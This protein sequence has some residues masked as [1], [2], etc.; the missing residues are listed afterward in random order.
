M[1]S[2]QG[3][4]RG[5]AIIYHVSG[6]SRSMSTKKTRSIFAFVSSEVSIP[7][8]YFLRPPSLVCELLTYRPRC[9][10]FFG[11]FLFEP[12][13][14]CQKGS[15]VLWLKVLRVCDAQACPGPR[16]HCAP[17]GAPLHAAPPHRPR[18]VKC[19]AMEVMDKK[20]SNAPCRV[21]L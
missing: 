15:L 5:V 18:P 16:R 13:P 10:F 1:F 6:T 12:S 17:H 2:Y 20:P 11:R 3:R 7:H 14:W 8:S 9:V 4:I 19:V 21:V